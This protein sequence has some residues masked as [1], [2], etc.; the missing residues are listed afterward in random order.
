MSM[1][2][3]I[4]TVLLAAFAVAP[5]GAVEAQ[6]TPASELPRLETVTVVAPRITYDT[7]VRRRT[8][9]GSA[10]PVEVTEATEVV[11]IQGLD[12]N[13]TADLFV[14]EERVEAAADR[15]CSGLQ[16]KHPDGEP[17]MEVCVDRAVEDAMAQ[18]RRMTRAA[19][20]RR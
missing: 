13:R 4:G 1:R 12:L 20:A 9:G 3:F 18:V 16:R 2:P 19:V 5:V 11:Q 10:L 14:L 17:K 6:D 7:E 8:S 15:V